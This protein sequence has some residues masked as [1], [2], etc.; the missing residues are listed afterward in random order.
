[1]FV[2]SHLMNEMQQT[3][4]HLVIIGRG[5]VI[6]DAPIATVIAGASRTAVKVRSPQP[7][8]LAGL[9]QRLTVAGAEV[10]HQGET[11][12]MVY[13]MPVEEVGGLAYELN[14]RLDELSVRESSLEEAYV[15]LTARSVEYRTDQPGGTGSGSAPRSSGGEGDQD[16]PGADAIDA[17]NHDRQ[18]VN[19]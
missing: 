16:R 14:V 3:A 11:V 1:L 15:E 18:E 4:D 10:E 13:G 12:A 5:K 6:S 9:L 2:S 17:R 7:G 19:R 8:A